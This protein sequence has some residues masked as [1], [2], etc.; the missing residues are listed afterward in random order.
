MLAD[1]RYAARLLLRQPAFTLIATLVL[2]LGIGA[3]TA[4]FSVVDAVL[5]RPLPY[6]DQ[7]RLVSLSTFWRQTG[8]R[9]QVSSP[10]F[11]DWHDRATSFDGMAALA[12]GETSVSV[13]GGADYARVARVT[14][15]FFSLFSARAEAGRLP[16]DAEQQEGG[17]LTAVV[18][19]SFWMTRLGG[20]R[21]ALGRTLK[22]AQRAYTI[23]G[24]L[25]PEF[26]YPAGTDV[27][28]PW[29]AVPPTTSR[30][31]HNYRAVGRLKPGVSLAQAQSELDAIASQL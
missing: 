16:T 8:L 29:W 17:P 21:A 28:T 11:Q 20:D 12:G 31:G 2:A 19:H 26:R 3:N 5:L 23:V 6:V 27:W 18:S 22:Y 9:G 15:E 4:I 13:D 1:L 14:P 25:P 24:V 7:D 10:D 30:S